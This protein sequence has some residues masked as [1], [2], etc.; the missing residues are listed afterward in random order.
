M[1]K[2][3]TSSPP[4]GAFGAGVSSPLIFSGWVK[5]VPPSR[6]ITANTVSGAGVGPGGALRVFRISP[7]TP[8][9]EHAIQLWKGVAG[10]IIDPHQ[11]LSENQRTVTVGADQLRSIGMTDPF[12]QMLS[13]KDP[14]PRL[15]ALRV[16]DPVHFVNLP[17]RIG[18]R[19]SHA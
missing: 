1:A 5:V 8:S 18:S 19:R 7:S 3:E 6:E 4:G 14:L 10:T 12:L 2:Y 11:S 9:G 17:V 15:H 13:D 16:S